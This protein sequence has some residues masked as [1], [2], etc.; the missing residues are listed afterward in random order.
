ML[1]WM[2]P[3][4]VLALAGCTGDSNK[5]QG[6]ETGGV[7]PAIVKSDA[8]AAQ[9]AQEFCQQYNRTARVT[10]KGNDAGGTTVFVCL[11][12]GKQSPFER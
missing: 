1:R 3:A 12:P 9:A 5:I 7:V 8:A 11:A 10:A 2:V 4:L 6:N